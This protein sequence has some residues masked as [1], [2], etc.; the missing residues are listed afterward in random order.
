MARTLARGAV[1]AGLAVVS[2]LARGIDAAAHQGALEGGGATWAVLGSGLARIYPPENEPWLAAS[3]TRGLPA[4]RISHEFLARNLAFSPAQPDRLRPFLGDGRGGGGGPFRV[5]WARPCTRSDR[6]GESSPFPAR[7]ILLERR[8]HQLLPRWGG[9]HVLHRRRFAGSFPASCGVRPGPRGAPPR[10]G[11]MG[12]V[13]NSRILGLG[14]QTVES[15]S[16]GDGA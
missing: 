3:W 8:P 9:P 14:P 5:P 16:R 2:G 10:F 15:L 13:E 1:K 7:R 11:S 12:S 4:Q 6:G